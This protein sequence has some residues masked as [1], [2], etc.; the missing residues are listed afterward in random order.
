MQNSSKVPGL[1]PEVRTVQQDREHGFRAATFCPI[2]VG[3]SPSSKRMYDVLNFGCIPVVLSDDLVW[4]YSPAT[5]GPLDPARFSIQLPQA[6]VQFPAEKLI[7]KYSATPEAF[8]WLRSGDSLYRMLVDAYTEGAEYQR[9]K[10]GSDAVGDSKKGKGKGKEKTSGKTR[11]SKGS[12]KPDAEEGGEGELVYVN[13]LVQILQRVSRNNIEL[14]RAGVLH[15]APSYRFYA[16]N[17]SMQ[18]IPTAEHVFPAGGAMQVGE[19][20]G[21]MAI[22]WA[23]IYHCFCMSGGR[24]V[25]SSQH[26]RKSSKFIVLFS[27]G[28][29]WL[30]YIRC[31]FCKQ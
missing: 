30:A 3:D 10:P 8:G 27:M 21:V 19:W 18:Q 25:K 13:A 22:L 14:L 29:H 31:E 15:V 24:P 16:M 12:E 17:E 9:G 26:K 2:P 20:R 6:V 5:G 1:V 11:D 23:M 28:A 4:A 7:K